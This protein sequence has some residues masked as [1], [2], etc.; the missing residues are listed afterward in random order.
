M[1]LADTAAFPHDFDGHIVA[2]VS[3]VSPWDWIINPAAGGD[4]GCETA[5][6]AGG[7]ITDPGGVARD[8]IRILKR[9]KLKGTSIR[10]M[11]GYDS[12]STALTTALVAQLFGR[13][14]SRD[15]WQALVNNN[16]DHEVTITP[17]PSTDPTGDFT[18]NV[19]VGDTT[20][21]RRWTVPDKDAHIW[22][23]DG[24]EEILA[25]VKTALNMTDG[26]DA[27]NILLAKCV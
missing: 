21:T 24:C 22:D 12:A 25:V 2:P 20:I 19:G 15:P 3:L 17:A 9:N 4:G 10:L 1:A 8:T 5:D 16:G 14:S 27:L 18:F 23:C 7:T 13:A 26:N 6:N 11:L